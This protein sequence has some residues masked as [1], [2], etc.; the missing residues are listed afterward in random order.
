MWDEREPE[1]YFQKAIHRVRF[2]ELID[3]QYFVKALRAIADDGRLGEYFTGTGIQHFI[4]RGLDSYLFPVP[5]LAEQQRI[6]SKVD[7]L[8]ALCDQLEAARTEREATRDRLVRASLARLSTPDPEP[9]VFARHT[10]FALDNLAAL[11]ARTDQIKDFR[12]TVLNLAV[13]GK[14]VR[15]HPDDGSAPVFDPTRHGRRRHRFSR[16]PCGRT[17]QRDAVNTAFQHAAVSADSSQQ[18]RVVPGTVNLACGDVAQRR[19]K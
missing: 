5:P 2:S 19:S 18:W 6:V 9:V 1:I 3:P 4:G 17:D 13:R 11:I 16:F 7:E 10:R 12:E 15:Q 8:M 14:L